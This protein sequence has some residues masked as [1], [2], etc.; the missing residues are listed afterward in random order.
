MNL[1]FLINGSSD[2]I[3]ASYWEGETEVSPVLVGVA[4]TIDVTPDANNSIRIY[5]KNG[6]MVDDVYCNFTYLDKDV[7]S[8]RRWEF[9]NQGDH[10]KGSLEK[11]GDFGSGELPIDVTATGGWPEPE[12]EPDPACVFTIEGDASLVKAELYDGSTLA[13]ELPLNVQQTVAKS[14]QGFQIIISPI[15]NAIIDE[16]SS[17]GYEYN[18]DEMAFIWAYTNL[19]DYYRLTLNKDAYFDDVPTVTTVLAIAPPENISPFNLLY[20][21]DDDALRDLSKA[22]PKILG[23]NNEPDNSGY[24]LNLLALPFKLP[25]DAIGSPITIVIG[26]TDTQVSAPTMTTDTVFIDLGKI[27]VGDLEGSSYDYTGATY[28]LV[29]PFLEGV[30]ELD[31]SQVVG[32]ELS[33]TYQLDLYKGDVTANVYS[34]GDEPVV[35]ASGRVGRDIPIHLFGRVE[36]GMGDFIPNNNGVLSAFIRVTKPEVVDGQFTNLVLVNESIGNTTGY[37]EVENADLVGVQDNEEVMTL[38]RAGIIIK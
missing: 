37:L 10:W 3:T 34:E 18:Q 4:D 36:N 38:L 26:N 15:D 27:V 31:A 2:Q 1:T 17:T 30:V 22:M 28:E 19:N 14:E 35:S 20:K 29:L 12:P 6:A 13:R 8:Y 32:K 16:V 5:P 21:L 23:R 33:V 11:A 24:M 25:D 9:T 7:Y